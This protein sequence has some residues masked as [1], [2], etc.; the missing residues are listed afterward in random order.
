[1]INLRI[2]FYCVVFGG[3]HDHDI[4]H[5]LECQIKLKFNFLNRKPHFYREF[6]TNKNFMCNMTL[7]YDLEPRTLITTLTMPLT[8]NLTMTLK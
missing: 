2:G 6:K 3:D 5:E 4:D 8:M 7:D 1:M